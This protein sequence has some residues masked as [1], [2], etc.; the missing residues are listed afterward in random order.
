[1]K[2]KSFAAASFIASGL[3][4]ASGAYAWHPDRSGDAPDRRGP[5][6]AEAQLA[7]LADRLQLTDEQSAQMLQVLQDAQADRQQIRDKIM[8]Q[9][10]PELCAAQQNTEQ[11]I[12]A[13]LTPEQA[14]LFAQMQEE[15]Q[16]SVQNRRGGGPIPPD[17]S[18]YDD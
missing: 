1:M 15:H 10:G 6:T 16:A 4:I 12:V 9:M 14:E 13:I 7:R 8:E 17:C 3:L 18:G 2:L 11:N 5:P